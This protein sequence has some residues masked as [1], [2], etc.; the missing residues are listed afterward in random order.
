MKK[1]KKREG[2]EGGIKESQPTCG[3]RG[4]V[5]PDSAFLRE[6]APRAEER[7]GPFRGQGKIKKHTPPGGEFFENLTYFLLRG[8]LMF[9]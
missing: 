2:R 3:I 4:H 7:G 5:G 1:R 9:F 8:G 6:S